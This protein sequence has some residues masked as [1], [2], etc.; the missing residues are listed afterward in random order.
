VPLI[1]TLAKRQSV[2]LWALAGYGFEVFM[3]AAEI[4]KPAFEA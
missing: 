1:V 2:T 3:K 4:H